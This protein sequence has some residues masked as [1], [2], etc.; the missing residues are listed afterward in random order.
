MYKKELEIRN[1]LLNIS[2]EKYQ[3]F[4]SALIPNIDNL[5]GVRIPT[6]RKISK[7]M[8]KNNEI[9]YLNKANDIYFEETMLKA[10]MIGNLKND[11]NFI[12]KQI[13]LFIPKIN[14][15]SICDSFCSELKIVRSNKDIVWKFLKKYYTSNE[16]YEIRF[17]IVLM[18]FHFI[19][20]DYIT[21]IIQVCDSITS[22]NYYVKMAVAWCL[23]ICFIKFPNQTHTYLLKN[24]LDDETFNKTIQKI[25]ESF[26]VDKETKEE[27][28]KLKRKKS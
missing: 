16:A 18:L 20:E 2:E 7:R 24:N 13:E 14:N 5:I 10:L 22:D 27:L 3:K 21:D 11:L 26:R 8:V 1:E 9:E 23:S 28:N 12:L 4:A 19:D 6:I 25:K 15:W 17:A